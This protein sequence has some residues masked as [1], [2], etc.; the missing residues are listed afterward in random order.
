MS[1]PLLL[2]RPYFYLLFTEGL[3]RYN[4][5]REFFL[6]LFPVFYGFMTGS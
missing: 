4:G 5:E 6:S 2:L 3:R 1:M